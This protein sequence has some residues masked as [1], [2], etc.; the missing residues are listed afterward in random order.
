MI[1]TA[2][3]IGYLLFG[4]FVHWLGCVAEEY[5]DDDDMLQTTGTMILFMIA[6][7]LT[8]F[9]L[10][11]GVMVEIIAFSDLGDGDK[12]LYEYIH[13]VYDSLFRSIKNLVT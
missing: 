3:V 5:Y 6:W 9:I 11:I 2:C 1:F 7:P 4:T 8:G 13:G 12:S 10:M